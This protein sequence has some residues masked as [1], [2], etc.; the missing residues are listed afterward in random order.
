MIILWAALGVAAPSNDFATTHSD[1]A[2][3]L[4]ELSGRQAAPL[5]ELVRMS[6]FDLTLTYICWQQWTIQRERRAREAKAQP[7]LAL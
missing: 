2:I 4:W 5:A 7:M 6:V 1:Q 3:L